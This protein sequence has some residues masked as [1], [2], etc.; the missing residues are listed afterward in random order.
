MKYIKQLTI[1]IDKKNNEVVQS[2]QY[3]SKTRF[4]HINLISNAIPFDITGCSVKVSGIKSDNTGIFNNCTVLNAKEGFIE[5][6][7][8]E[9]MNAVEGLVKCELKIYD[10]KGVLTTK[11]FNINVTSS[12]S[13]KT[14]E[15][16]NEFGAL[17]EAL[18]KVNNID[19]KFNE[20]TADA[21]KEAAEIE[22]QKQIA[23]GTMANLTIANG[24]ITS[25]KLGEY[26]VTQEK[27]HP[28]VKLGVQINDN[29]IN[30]NETWSSFKIGTE[31]EN[32][33]TKTDFESISEQTL[34]YQNGY[35]GGLQKT[36]S[37]TFI[38]WGFP[39]NK[40]KILN[41]EYI[42]FY[43][44]AQEKTTISFSLMNSNKEK[45]FVGQSKTVTGQTVVDFSLID[46]P[47][48]I[49]SDIVYLTLESDKYFNMCSCKKDA[50]PAAP[51]FKRAGGNWANSPSSFATF[52]RLF[53]V[54]YASKIKKTIKMSDENKEEFYNFYNKTE[55]YNKNEVYDM[56]EVFKEQMKMYTNTNNGYD[57]IIIAG[58]S[59]AVGHGKPYDDILD[60]PQNN[61]FQFKQ[62]ETVEIAKDPLDHVNL[63]PQGEIGFGLSFA[64]KYYEKYCWGGR[65]VL[66]VPCA[67]SGTKLV[68]SSWH[69][70]Q[71]SLYTKM[72]ERT[73]KA[74]NLNPNNRLIGVLWHQ[75]ESDSSE[76]KETYRD[77]LIELINN[78][79]EDVGVP[80]CPFLLGE[81]NNN[82]PVN[83]VNALKEIPSLINY[84]YFVSCAGLTG[85]INDTIHFD[86]NSLREYGKRFS[87]SLHLARINNPYSIEY[88]GSNSVFKFNKVVNASS[89]DFINALTGEPVFNIINNELFLVENSTKWNNYCVGVLKEQVNEIEFNFISTQAFIPVPILYKGIGGHIYTQDLSGEPSLQWE[90]NGY[91]KTLSGAPLLNKTI[92]ARVGDNVKYRLVNNIVSVFVND[93]EITSISVDDIKNKLIDLGYDTEGYEVRFGI[94]YDGTR[95]NALI[96]NI[97]LKYI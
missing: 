47:T 54:D 49:N 26:S 14:V 2:V 96:S 38:A 35:Y 41:C 92:R 82:S 66:I 86:S 70:R 83:V 88:P 91:F 36:V 40:D 58:Q 24:S 20:L 16:S 12:V 77:T 64:K 29:N 48:N 89:E 57:I 3:D 53:R 4:I 6:E 43:L 28:N 33:L 44:V 27:I 81:P 11:Q 90:Y 9:Q 73:I 45:I 17:T 42:E 34:V 23:N 13:S 5:V 68:N 63:R 21:I 52:F 56:I 85:N 18:N 69:P 51:I 8:T 95:T 60:A 62:D 55:V 72:V 50:S 84:T 25:D 30:T 76:T 87:N 19:N 79:R 65:K 7:V 74:L 78:F 71:G 22:I 94:S 31:F 15:S 97:K 61:I 75:G 59:N 32:V 80:N 1:D 46:I 10:G 39:I 93:A 67:S 37:D